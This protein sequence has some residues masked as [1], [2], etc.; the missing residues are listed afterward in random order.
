MRKEERAKRNEREREKEKVIGRC[1]TYR[2]RRRK[3]RRE[4]EGVQGLTGRKTELVENR[5]KKR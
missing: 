2:E 1:C 4:T 5:R 3:R